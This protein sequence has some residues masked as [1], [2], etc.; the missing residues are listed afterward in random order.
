MQGRDRS[1][2]QYSCF[3]KMKS[4]VPT[5][6]NVEKIM[7]NLLL[8]G[9]VMELTIEKCASI[10]INVT[11]E[12][13]MIIRRSKVYDRYYKRTLNDF[14]NGVENRILSYILELDKRIEQQ[15]NNSARLKGLV[16]ERTNLM[17][18]ILLKKMTKQGKLSTA[19][20]V[21]NFSGI[22][23]TL[24]EDTKDED[25]PLQEPET[26]YKYIPTIVK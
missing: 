22:K 20:V 17:K 16:E 14:I 6:E 5:I 11:R 23:L 1:F 9:N 26:E 8:S 24:V 4:F 3:K 15:D 19:E 18:L 7:W 13:L 2:Q 21:E 12:E 25:A 10:G